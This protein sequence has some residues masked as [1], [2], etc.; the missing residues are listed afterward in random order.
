MHAKL[1]ANKRFLCVSGA[2]KQVVDD[3]RFISVP[4]VAGNNAEPPG[5]GFMEIIGFLL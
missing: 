3:G 5:V 1:I 2:V 4:K